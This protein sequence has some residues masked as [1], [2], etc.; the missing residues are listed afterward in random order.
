MFNKK[1]YNKKY[2][3]RWYQENKERI[4]AINREY[5]R[6]HPWWKHFNSAQQRCRSWQSYKGV[7]E[8]HLTINEVKTLWFRDKADEMKKPSIDRI[9]TTGNYTKDNCRFIEFLDNIRRPRRKYVKRGNNAIETFP[10]RPCQR[11]SILARN[12][13][14]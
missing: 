7:V 5:K 9:E 13:V 4:D 1:E 2:K 3:V 8:F 12:V 6:T 10:S 14:G 11:V